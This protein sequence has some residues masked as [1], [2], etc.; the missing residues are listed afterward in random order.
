MFCF[1]GAGSSSKW[2]GLDNIL[3]SKILRTD[4][5]PLRFMRAKFLHFF[6]CLNLKGVFEKCNG[7][8]INVLARPGPGFKFTQMNSRVGLKHFFIESKL[9]GSRGVVA[10]EPD[11]IG[12][13]NNRI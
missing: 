2:L 8:T 12:R 1:P 13:P 6:G 11:M 5:F 10:S 9:M 7:V 4:N 3:Q